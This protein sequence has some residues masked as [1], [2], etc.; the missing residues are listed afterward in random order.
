MPGLA[1]NDFGD[2]I[3]YGASTAAEDEQDLE[4]VR[5]DLAL[6]EAYTRGYFSTACF[7]YAN[8]DCHAAHGSQN[9]DAGVRHAL[10]GR[11]YRG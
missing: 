1:V 4:R 7:A 10:F 6:F 11:P 8:G 2:A 3:R 9:D 5:F